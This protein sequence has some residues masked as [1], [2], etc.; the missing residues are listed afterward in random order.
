MVMYYYTVSFT[1]LSPVSTGSKT[2]RKT[3]MS[4]TG[5]NL[6]RHMH[7]NHRLLHLCCI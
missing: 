1:V 6:L 3:Q 7:S 5:V 4:P 2:A